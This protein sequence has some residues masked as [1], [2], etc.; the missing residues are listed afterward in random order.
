MFFRKILFKIIEP[1]VKKLV[2]DAFE[3][4]RHRVYKLET[5]VDKLILTMKDLTTLNNSVETNFREDK[6]SIQV[7]NE[8][9]KIITKGLRGIYTLLEQVISI[10]TKF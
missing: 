8:N 7:L 1:L 10:N 3:E 5:N 9:M 2:D 4:L 6:E